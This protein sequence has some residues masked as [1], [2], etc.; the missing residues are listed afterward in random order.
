MAGLAS[1]CWMWRLIWQPLFSGVLPLL[2]RSQICI[3]REL[4]LE[5]YLYLKTTRYSHQTKSSLRSPLR[6]QGRDSQAAVADSRTLRSS[7]ME[8]HERP[9]QFTDTAEFTTSRRWDEENIFK[10]GCH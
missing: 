5:Q 9:P 4:R 8:G 10:V 6:L 3:R 2:E 1:V 7:F